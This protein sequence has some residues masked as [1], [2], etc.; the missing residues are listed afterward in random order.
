[1]NKLSYLVGLATAF[2][3]MTVLSPSSV[4]AK[5]TNDARQE[6]RIP[7]ETQD[8]TAFA[9]AEAASEGTLVADR[10]DRY[11][12]RAYRRAD[13]YTPYRSYR[14]NYDYYPRR[15]GLSI[16]IGTS[17]RY[18]S[19]YRYSPYRSYYAPRSGFG[20]SIGF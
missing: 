7:Q 2:S 3:V 9:A 14:Y 12:R 1:M 20:F 19:G 4:Q 11:R 18:Y 13:R 5:D 8:V 10:W 16:G 6:L 17:P 15:S